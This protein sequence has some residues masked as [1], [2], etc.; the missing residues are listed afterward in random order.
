MTPSI[1]PGAAVQK[2]DVE[3][4]GDDQENVTEAGTCKSQTVDLERIAVTGP[5]IARIEIEGIKPVQVF[6][7]DD[8]QRGFSNLYDCDHRRL[9]RRGSDEQLPCQR[10]GIE[11]SVLQSTRPRRAR[12]GGYFDVDEFTWFQST[13]SRSARHRLAQIFRARVLVSIHTPAKGAT[14]RRRPRP[15]SYSSFNPHAREGRDASTAKW[16][17]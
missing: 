16:A 8:L 13:R 5:R 10:A 6:T 17:G 14:S 4:A 3:E 15:R 2:Q 1:L 12:H 11:A 9:R 7:V